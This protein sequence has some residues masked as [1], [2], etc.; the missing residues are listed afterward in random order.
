[1]KAVLKTGLATFCLTAGTAWSAPITFN[2]A[3]P[4]REGGYVLREQFVF[5]K[6]ADDPTPAGRDMEASALVSVLGYGVTRDFALFGMLPWFDKR[7]DMSKGGQD[8]TRQKS[9]VGDL[10]VFGRYTAYEFNAQGKTFRIAPFLGVK[11]PTGE[12]N[13][14]DGVGRLP[15][16]VQLGSGSWDVL[17]GA[18]LTYQT[19]DFEIDSQV[20]YKANTDANGFQAGNVASLDTSFQYRLWP[21]SLGAGVPAFLYGVLEANLVHSA[22][23]RSGGADD[24][25]S[26]GTT[27]FITPGL[28]YVTQKWI[29]EAG[30]Q[31]PA[32]QHLNGTALKNDYVFTTGFRVNF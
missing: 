32:S 22:R 18:V 31:I 16:P 29:V 6:S 30:V 8:L 24:P 19:L 4:V 27:L 9:G 2:T 7:L 20:S 12:D 21:R 10:T 1:M 13:A 3:L 11:A 15:P 26:G 5:M 23:D 25:N 28:Q 17:G 14:R